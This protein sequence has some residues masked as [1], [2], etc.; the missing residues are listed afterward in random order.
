MNL[1]CKKGHKLRHSSL[2]ELLVES[3]FVAAMG[4]VFFKDVA[5][6]SAEFFQD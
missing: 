3:T 2:V 5:V 6:A 1:M 4:G